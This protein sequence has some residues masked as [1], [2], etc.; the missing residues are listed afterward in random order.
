MCQSHSSDTICNNKNND[1]IFMNFSCST[2]SF[3]LYK[4]VYRCEIKFNA[5][6]SNI[7]LHQKAFSSLKESSVLDRK[8]PLQ[9]KQ[10]YVNAKL[11]AICILMNTR[12]GREKESTEFNQFS[13]VPPILFDAV[14]PEALN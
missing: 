11:N 1:V 12:R 5:I 14:K 10:S 3:L 6:F 7:S 13:S 4:Y 8:S 9:I 2:L